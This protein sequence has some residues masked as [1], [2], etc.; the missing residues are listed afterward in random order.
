MTIL[1]RI[2]LNS[3]KHPERVVMR[4]QYGFGEM[5]MKWGELDAFSD[6]LAYYLTKE[7]RTNK[8]IIVYGHKHPMML[9]CFL[10]CVKSGRAYCPIDVNVPLSRTEAI[11]RE[12]EPEI[13]LTTEP[14]EIDSDRIKELQE[15]NEIIST[16]DGKADSSNY[17]TAEDVFYII[18]TSGSTGT[19]KGVQITR[20]CLDNFIKWALCLGSGT[21]QEKVYTFMNQAPFSFDL[22]VMDLYLCLYT[23]GTLFALGKNVQVDMKLLYEALRRSG[24]NK[25]ISTPSFADVCLADPIFSGELLPD[26]T[27]FLF[28][29]EILTNKTV[30]RLKKRFP[31]ANVVNTYGPTESTCAITEINVTDEI[32]EKY[33]PLPVGKP[34]DGTWIRYQMK[35]AM[36]WSMGK[37][38]RL[39]LLAIP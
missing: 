3:A 12:V 24:I 17:V 27:D 10:A 1:E 16:T 11:I 25:W 31:G 6:K 33:S 15:I 7:L 26:L 13:I 18:F 14:L 29:G 5:T 21:A 37:K 39:S 36:R 8:P 32:N 4:T 28:C 2:K 23:G 35:T 22:S 19:P 30:S 34:K 20:D 38:A 9:V